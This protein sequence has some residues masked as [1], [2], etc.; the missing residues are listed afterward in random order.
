M[1]TRRRLPYYQA[2]RRRIRR[3]RDGLLGLWLKQL[4]R[5]RKEQRR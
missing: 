2:E 4:R 1:T 5:E 3:E